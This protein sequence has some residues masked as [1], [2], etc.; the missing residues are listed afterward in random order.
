MPT[1]TLEELSNQRRS[2]NIGD[3]AETKETELD[4]LLRQPEQKSERLRKRRERDRG[5]RA[6]Q[7]TSERQANSQQRSTRERER[8]AAETPEEKEDYSRVVPVHMKEWQLK[9]PRREKED[10]SGWAS[11]STKGWQLNPGGD[12]KLHEH[13]PAWKVGRLGERNEVTAHAR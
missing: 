8:M 13:Q 2:K 3:G 12:R 4:V 7:T 5:R 10:Y 1:A 9:P 6:A 11:T